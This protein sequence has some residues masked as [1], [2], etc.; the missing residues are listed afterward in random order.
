[1][2]NLIVLYECHIL[3]K[4]LTLLARLLKKGGKMPFFVKPGSKWVII[5]Q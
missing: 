3:I 2:F 4:R 1:M 5:I